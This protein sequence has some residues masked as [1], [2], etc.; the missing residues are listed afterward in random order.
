[1]LLAGL[2]PALAARG[3]SDDDYFVLNILSVGVPRTVADLDTLLSLAGRRVTPAQVARLA[4]RRLVRACTLQPG[5][6]VLD[7]A[8]TGAMLEM[9][10]ISKAAEE[11]AL[12][13]IDYSEAHLLK[14]LLKRVIRNTLRKTQPALWPA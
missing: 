6:W 3:L 11:D 9:A 1:M 10:A 7:D 14:H 8:G 13:Q 2:R 12:Q 5:C 4:E